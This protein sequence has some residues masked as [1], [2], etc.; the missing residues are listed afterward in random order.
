MMATRDSRYPKIECTNL[1]KFIELYVPWVFEAIDIHAIMIAYIL[2]LSNFNCLEPKRM[3]PMVTGD[4]K[5]TVHLCPVFCQLRH[6]MRR[7]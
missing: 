2:S 6:S 7:T 5:G 1:Y 4:R 3:A